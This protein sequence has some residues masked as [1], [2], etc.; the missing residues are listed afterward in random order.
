[1][2]ES[3]RSRMKVSPSGTTIRATHVAGRTGAIQRRLGSRP[4]APATVP[5]A[6]GTRCRHP[7]RALA[8]SEAILP[9]ERNPC[10]SLPSGNCPRLPRRLPCTTHQDSPPAGLR[11]Q[12]ARIPSGVL[13][14][15]VSAR[16]WAPTS[17]SRAATQRAAKHGLRRGR[18]RPE[19]SDRSVVPAVDVHGTGTRRPTGGAWGFRR[20]TRRTGRIPGLLVVL[21]TRDTR[22]LPPASFRATLEDLTAD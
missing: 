17:G 20:A 6:I 2:I 22:S 21:A 1:M 10:W 14:A 13:T 19:H 11:F 9:L 5:F 15:R 8:V 18:G 3:T 7:A 4:G 12:A 16:R